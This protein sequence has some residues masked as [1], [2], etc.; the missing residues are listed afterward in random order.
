MQDAGDAQLTEPPGAGTQARVP[1]AT[2]PHVLLVQP[3]A[4]NA[5]AQAIARMLATAL[6]G[7]GYRTGQIFFYRKTG[8]FDA[9]P[10]VAFCAA[11][12]PRTPLAF[13]RFFLDLV[14]RIRRARPDAVLCFQHYGNIIGAAAA[15]LAGVP[16]VIANQNSARDTTPPRARLVD[17]W[18]GALG[19]YGRIVVNSHDSAGDLADY[20]AG[21]RARVV[22][23]DHGFVGR[24]SALTLAEARA[25]L[26]LALP[27]GGRLL[28][29]VAR[30][31]P[32]KNLEAAVRLL[33]QDPAWHLALAGQGAERDAL[34]GLAQRLGC[35]ARLHLVGE[36]PPDRV[37]DFLRALDVF[38][39]PSRAETFGLAAVEAAQAGVP[40]VANALPVL[41]EVLATDEGPC[42]LFVDT[43]DGAAFAEAVHRLE[44]EPD[45]ATRLVRSGSGLGRRFPVDTMAEAYDT[46]LRARIA[47]S[48]PA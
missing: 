1:A 21:Y 16:V 29:C 11:E 12:R 48:R 14:R 31:H 24:D 33:P 5:G 42:A 25:R 4:E 8:A 46:L 38:V 47:A 26:G 7:R 3:Q 10:G 45:L 36:L 30:L 9:E 15:R 2:G 44:R 41:R 40:V 18:L 13:L 20:P 39:F 17:R 6:A 37:G 23:I 32:L 43:E 34:A 35:A 27:A 22:H 28:G 19:L